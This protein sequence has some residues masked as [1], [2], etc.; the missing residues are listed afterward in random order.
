MSDIFTCPNCGAKMKKQIDD[1]NHF[2]ICPK[3][4]CSIDGKEQYFDS[5]FI[6]PN[7]HNLLENNIECYYCGYD[8]GS[9][10]D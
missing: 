10:F 8:L 5:G 2:H 6:C 4:G 3:C 9:D 1:M 7:C